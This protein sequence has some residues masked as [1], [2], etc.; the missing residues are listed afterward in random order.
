MV[1][2]RLDFLRALA[3]AALALCLLLAGA[4][5]RNADA[6]IA[7]RDLFPDVGAPAGPQA[8]ASAAGAVVRAERL[9]ET[10]PNDSPDRAQPL[11]A[12]AV[13][14]GTLARAVAPALPEPPPEAPAA[15]PPAKGKR[16][17]M[18][19]VPAVVDADWFRLPAV[20]PG[21]AMQV[22]LRSGPACAE[23]EVHDDAGG[24]LLRKA[25]FARGVRPA[26]GPLGTTAGASMVRV[27]CRAGKAKTDEVVGGAYELAVFSRPA[28]PGE[29]LEPD[30]VARSDL[31]TLTAG[32]SLQGCLSPE[33]DVDHFALGPGG[34]QPGEALALSVT[35]APDVEWELVLLGP[36]QKPLLVRS[37]AKGQPVVI[38]NLDVQALPAG[39]LLQVR[40]KKGQAPDTPYAVSLQPWLPTGCTRAA[41]CANLIPQEREPNDLAEGPWLVPWQ[42]FDHA[43]AGVLGGV[44]DVDQLALPVPIGQV[45]ALTL[46]APPSVG[47]GVQVTLAGAQ[48]WTVTV[49]PGTVAKLPGLAGAAQ[50]V[51]LELRALPA[52]ANAPDDPYRVGWAMVDA[53][54]WETEVGDEAAGGQAWLPAAALAALTDGPALPGGG[55]QRRGVLMPAGDRDAFGLD[56]REATA[57]AGLELLCGGDG[58]VGFVCA[59]QDVA[60]RDLLRLSAGAD[61]AKALLAL[62]P[63]AYRL[64]VQ[65]H[66]G[67]QSERPYTVALR[68]AAEAASLPVA[69]T[70]ADGAGERPPPTLP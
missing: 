16:P 32:T 61:G 45:V 29:A 67:R 30:D 9:V 21:Q 8:V 68:R 11:S 14:A 22:E 26:F 35:G 34:A 40:A 58:A 28:Q 70:A 41:D 65:G 4:C 42:P 38:P 52:G 59:V 63:G 15:K 5:R 64:V 69:G 49:P 18:A 54:T 55:W 20:A 44:G 39:S 43:V 23:L 25:R 19:A 36:D 12:N 53:A 13:V 24:K 3:G 1:E 10:E 33:G 51:R 56:L 47:L 57:V 6:P 50:P 60:G 17:K 7:Q 37:P 31:P 2:N 62:G 46:H 48:P 27:V 66:G